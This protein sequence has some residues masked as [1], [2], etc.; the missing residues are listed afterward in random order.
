MRSSNV[1]MDDD[2]GLGEF[3]GWEREWEGQSE[4]LM[5]GKV[6]EKI[7]VDFSYRD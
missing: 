7:R 2:R 6:R 5:S 4:P 1:I 3:S